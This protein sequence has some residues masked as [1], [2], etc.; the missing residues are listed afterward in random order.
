MVMVART[1]D[2]RNMPGVQFPSVVSFRE[3]S[4]SHPDVAFL[5]PYNHLLNLAYLPCSSNSPGSSTFLLVTSGVE[6]R[7]LHV[8]ERELL[9]RK[10]SLSQLLAHPC[11]EC[12]ECLL[13]FQRWYRREQVGPSRF[14]LKSRATSQHLTNCFPS[15]SLLLS[16]DS[17]R[18]GQGFAASRHR[19]LQRAELQHLQC[20][21]HVLK[22]FPSLLLHLNPI[23]H[24]FSFFSL[25]VTCPLHV[26]IC[27]V[28]FYFCKLRVHV[29]IL[30]FLYVRQGFLQPALLV[31]RFSL[32]PFCL[33][34]CPSDL[35]GSSSSAFLW[36]SVLWSLQV[37]SFP[38]HRSC[39]SR[40]IHAPAFHHLPAL[41]FPLVCT[42]DFS[43]S[44]ASLDRPFLHL[45]C[46][47][48]MFPFSFDIPRC[49]PVA[50][51]SRAT[52]CIQDAAQ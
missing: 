19:F 29:C 32:G 2:S 42:V 12:E 10:S 45:L 49:V 9:L 25:H 7:F 50:L 23:Q 11:H 28:D 38:S 39:C 33:T 4:S 27:F 44:G 41:S 3:W 31:F 5:T 36:L 52:T 20:L 47:S 51:S 40:Q 30:Q 24:L 16:V 37:C 43:S 8:D 34:H 14:G 35:F 1:G 26:R 46:P 13:R 6:M 17:L 15:S 48:I 18:R 22:L 21:D